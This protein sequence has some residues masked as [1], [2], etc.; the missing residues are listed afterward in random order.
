MAVFWPVKSCQIHH[1]HVD[2]QMNHAYHVPSIAQCLGQYLN[3]LGQSEH[4]KIIVCV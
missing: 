3:I 4:G 1:L 2:N